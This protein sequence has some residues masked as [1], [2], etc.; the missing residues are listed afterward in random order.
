MK[1]IKLLSCLMLMAIITIATSAS[2][3]SPSI[4]LP[5]QSHTL[6]N[7]PNWAFETNQAAQLNPDSR[8]IVVSSGCDVNGDGYDDIIVGSP[9]YDTPSFQDAGRA[10][11]FLGTKNGL[12]TI[13]SEVF[14]HPYV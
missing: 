13:P 11:L 2:A 10:W 3:S 1:T 6:V 14:D 12:S 7:P 8:S 4:S 9:G 5:Y